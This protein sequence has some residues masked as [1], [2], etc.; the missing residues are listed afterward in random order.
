MKVAR[1]VTFVCIISFLAVAAPLAQGTSGSQQVPSVPPQPSVPPGATNPEQGATQVAQD[2]TVPD[3][4]IDRV[5]KEGAVLELGL[6]DAIRLALTNNLNLE[7]ENYNENLNRMRVFGTKGYYDPVLSFSFGWNSQTRP[8]T[9]ILQAGQG[10]PTSIQKTWTFNTGLT[11]NVVGGGQFELSFDNNRQAT[12]STF[13]TVNPQF[14]TNFSLNYT[15]PLWRGFR[16]TQTE[17]DLKLYNL[18]TEIS[19]TQFQERVS[20]TIQQ[21]EDQYWELVYSIRNYEA[22]RRGL[23]M[24]IIQYRNNQKRVEIGVMAPIEITSSQAEVAN[25]QQDMITSE[26]QIITAQN[27]LKN[28]LAPDPKATLWSETLIPIDEPQVKEVQVTLDDAVQTALENRPELKRWNLQMEQT[29]I[30]RNYLH[31]QGKP[32]V[33]LVVGL[34]SIGTSG[35]VYGSSFID[36]NGDG[37]PDTEVNHV[38]Q[39]G[40]PLYGNFT[41][42]FGQAFGLDYLSYNAA[43]NV[44]IPLRNRANE[45]QLAQN[46]ITRRQQESNLRMEQQ[47]VMVDVRNAYQAIATRRKALDAAQ[48]ARRLSQEKL[49]GENKRFEA[50]LS[51]N[52]EVLSYQRDLVNAQVNELRAMVNYQQ[53]LTALQTAMF[54]IISENDIVTARRNGGQ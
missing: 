48:A 40:S 7:I 10:V 50:G 34:T 30:S 42:S 37:V 39:P 35:V 51:T 20:Q 14:G 45:A 13:F 22:Q 41:N 11:Q 33:D 3:S 16:E 2:F 31:N 25:R 19:D 17:R 27:T 28:L 49:D 43:V 46:L 5:K 23:E 12:N 36:T 18:D 21:V 52:F 4:Y 6:K 32:Q 44:Q 9:S 1:L 54:T 29:G 24:A 53:A 47:T 8:A 38:P 15:Q 26:V